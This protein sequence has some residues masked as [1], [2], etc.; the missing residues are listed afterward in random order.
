MSAKSKLGINAG[1][2]RKKTTPSAA[3]PCS[4][5]ILD[6]PNEI[7]WWWAWSTG[8]RRW[9]LISISD[10]DLAEK[11]VPKSYEWWTK[12]VPPAASTT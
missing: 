8:S 3:T 9:Y 5:A 12:C 11:N 2:G 6:Y 10:D 7:G 1:G 4:A